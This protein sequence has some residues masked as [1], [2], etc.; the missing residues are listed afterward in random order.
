MGL[1]TAKQLFTDSSEETV[2]ITNNN[3]YKSLVLNQF[4]CIEKEVVPGHGDIIE[5]LHAALTNRH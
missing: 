1:F 2:S 4:I 5:G 3:I